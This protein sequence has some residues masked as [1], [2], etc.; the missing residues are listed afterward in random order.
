M[1]ETLMLPFSKPPPLNRANRTTFPPYFHDKPVSPDPGYMSDFVPFCSI[2][3]TKKAGCIAKKNTPRPGCR[4]ALQRRHLRTPEPCLENPTADDRIAH[5]SR[6]SRMN[7]LCL[8]PHRGTGFQPVLAILTL[9]NLG[10]KGLFS[11]LP[12]NTGWKPV[13]Q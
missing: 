9:E 12:S 10:K 3:R 4:R 11:H 7:R 1:G 2:P 8:E 13:P 5:D 6:K